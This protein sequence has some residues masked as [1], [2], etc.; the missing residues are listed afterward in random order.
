MGIFSKS[1]KTEYAIP[2]DEEINGLIAKFLPLLDGL[3]ETVVNGSVYRPD[4]FLEDFKELVYFGAKTQDDQLL[5]WT[6][7]SAQ[8]VYFTTNGE[9]S[10]EDVAKLHFW[11]F[12]DSMELRKKYRDQTNLNDRIVRLGVGSFNISEMNA[13]HKDHLEWLSQNADKLN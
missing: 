10:I 1:K 4:D 3:V 11:T 8:L 12:S 5:D 2:S 6:I 9:A 7:K 13:S